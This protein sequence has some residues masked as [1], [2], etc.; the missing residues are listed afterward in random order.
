MQGFVLEGFPKTE[1]QLQFLE[2]ERISQKSCV[3]ALENVQETAYNRVSYRKIDPFTGE[4]YEFGPNFVGKNREISQEIQ[5]R[6][7]TMPLD[8]LESLRKR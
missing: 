4:I 5:E 6:L 3:I 2:N 8:T 1:K 7:Q